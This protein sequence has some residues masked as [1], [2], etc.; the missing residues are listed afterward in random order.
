M[1]ARAFE[2]VEHGG[3]LIGV[4]Y[5]D[6]GSFDLRWRHCRSDIAGYHVELDCFRQSTVQNAIGTTDGASMKLATIT[7]AEPSEPRLDLDRLEPLKLY[8]PEQRIDLPFDNVAI[9]RATSETNPI[10]P[11]PQIILY[12]EFRGVGQDAPVSGVEQPREFE[13]ANTGCKHLSRRGT[14]ILGSFAGGR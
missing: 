1:Q 13:V 5:H 8:L 12:P 9:A 7:R 2:R 4:E 14:I 11:L 6:L 10:E 3:N